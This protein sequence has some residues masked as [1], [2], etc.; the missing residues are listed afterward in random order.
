[1]EQKHIDLLYISLIYLNKYQ[2]IYLNMSIWHQSLSRKHI[3]PEF[4]QSQTPT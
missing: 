4:Q 1:M 3:I 2:I